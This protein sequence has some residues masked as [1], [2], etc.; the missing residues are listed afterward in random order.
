MNG[1]RWTGKGSVVPDLNGCDP[2]PQVTAL[3][4]LV[5]DGNTV[6]RWVYPGCP[7]G[8][9]VELF[10]IEGGEHPWLGSP[11]DQGFLGVVSQDIVASE[12]LVEFLAGH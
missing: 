11:I 7:S 12:I 2:E 9:S 4:E 10:A 5:D 6:E 8:G 3:P 1:G